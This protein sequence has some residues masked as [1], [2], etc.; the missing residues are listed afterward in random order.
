MRFA[1]QLSHNL[2]PLAVVELEIRWDVFKPK[3]TQ[4]VKV[5]FFIPAQPGDIENRIIGHMLP[6]M[7]VKVAIIRIGAMGADIGN[8]G[9]WRI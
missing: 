1:F 3:Y 5:P 8:R 6:A 9:Y 7:A 2:L 4:T